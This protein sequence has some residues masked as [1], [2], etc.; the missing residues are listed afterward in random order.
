MTAGLLAG[1][2]VSCSR[3]SGP[4]YTYEQTESSHAG[5]RR[6][7][8]TSGGAVYVND[9]EEYSLRLANPEP[10]QTVGRSKFG[11]GKICA[12]PGQSPSAYLA[13]DVGSEMPAY[14]VFRNV[15]QPVFDWRRATFQ[16]LVLATLEGPAANKTTTDSALIEDVLRTLR[17]G[18]LASLPPQLLNE[19]HA[20]HLFSDRLPGLIF[21][22]LVHFDKTG[23]VYLAENCW[24]EFTKTN[25]LVHAR[26]IPAS[27]QFTQWAQTR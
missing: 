16:K 20:V 22:P 15:Q 7:T 13:A 23:Q 4:V 5:Y 18:A 10:T 2:C 11:N 3:E 6:T 17:E 12:I 26:W 14:E 25:Q 27:P 8:I 1:L 19:V 24:I 21:C 9:F